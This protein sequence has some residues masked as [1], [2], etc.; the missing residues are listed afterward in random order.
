VL[1]TYGSNSLEKK[2][3][4]TGRRDEVPIF[5]SRNDT[6]D[7]FKKQQKPFNIINLY[8]RDVEPLRRFPKLT[9]EHILYEQGMDMVGA[10]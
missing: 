6:S 1:S 7:I 10:Q 2:E 9:K 5:V 8:S 4:S 3:V